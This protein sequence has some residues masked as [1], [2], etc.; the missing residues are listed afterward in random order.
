MN[1]NYKN[2]ISNTVDKFVQII[3]LNKYN[4]SV[5][6]KLSS[7]NNYGVNKKILFFFVIESH[8]LKDRSILIIS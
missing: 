6:Q 8:I 3:I 7:P 2:E 4:P 5:R 1:L